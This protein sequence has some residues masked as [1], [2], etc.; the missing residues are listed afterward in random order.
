MLWR[1]C[2]IVPGARVT[3]IGMSYD[4]K[5]KAIG[6]DESKNLLFEAGPLELR[7]HAELLQPQVARKD[8]NIPEMLVER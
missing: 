7:G 4:F 5:L 2:G 8:P 6:I 3:D 1:N